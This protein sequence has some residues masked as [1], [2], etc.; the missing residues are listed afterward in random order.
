MPM[1][2]LFP[3]NCPR[4]S[5]RI[6]ALVAALAAAATS[7]QTSKPG[8]AVAFAPRPE[9]YHPGWIDL[10]K[11]GRKDVYEDPAAP[12]DAR[13]DDLLARMTV[14]EKTAQMVTL[15][16]YGRVLDD[17]LPTLRWKQ[18][19]WKDG[20]ANIDEHLNA[21][22]DGN[23]H[24]DGAKSQYALDF[25]KH[26]WAMDQVQRFFIEQTRL[27]IPADFTNEGLRG[28]PSAFS[29]NFPSE[30][31]VGHT[32]DPE[33]AGR[34]GGVMAIE[35]RAL[36]YTNIY[37]PVLDVVRDQRWGRTEESY[38]EDPFLA[39]RMGVAMVKGLQ[40]D[41]RIASTAKHFAVY[42]ANKGARE[43]DARTDPQVAPREVEDVL[44]PPFEAAIREAGLLGVMSSYNDYDGVPIT[45][46]K[47]WLTDR[48]RKE[49]GFRGYVVSDS[50]AVEFLHSKHAV[51]GDYKEAVRQA[52]DAG[53][54]VR[55][56]FTPPEVYLTPLRALVREG[57]LPMA[58]IDARVRDVLRVKFMLGLFDHPYIGD[59]KA[60]RAKVDTEE[61]RALA[62]RAARE[63]L[64]LLKNKEGALPLRKDLKT[65][66]VIGPNA[67]DAS[68]AHRQYGPTGGHAISVREGIATKLGSGVEVRY[69]KGVEI[70]G[71]NW[72]S[73]EILPE[74][75]TAEEQAGIDEAVRA[76]KGADIAVV[77]LGDGRRTVGESR[78]RTSLDLP[79][80]Q[81]ALLEAVAA[82]G[83]PVVLVL[84]NGRPM[85]V[86]WADAH[87]PAILEAWF[88]GNQG[89]TAVADALFGDDNPGGKLTVTFPKT[90]GQ[91]PFNFPTKPNAQWEGERSRVNGALYNFGHGLSY[92]T[93]AYDN[94]RVTPA[95]QRNG[96]N[97][98]VAVD[99]RNS[100]ARAGDEVVQL[101]TRDVVSS[102]TTYE[103]NLRG[104][105]RVHL[106]PGETRTIRFTLKPADLALLNRKMQRVV[107]PGMFRVMVGSASDDI[108]Q[109]GEFEIV[110]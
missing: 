79:G 98:E 20:V 52:V 10:D 68:Y 26:V 24:G 37:A 66:A 70:A 5:L 44:L 42:S 16:G 60:A 108:R 81:E 13:I 40:R 34:I 91:I 85:S 30:L 107:E 61:D 64:V 22:G 77:V 17:E 54:N 96:G 6:V 65:I 11:N 47:Y 27:G 63:S 57:K 4:S 15:Y 51:A 80:R 46:S 94:L 102:V 109:Q 82:T 45:G 55:T 19:P 59:A 56:T 7:A 41:H 92:T 95:K 32:W 69:A 87:V 90:A 35:A 73:I 67:D 106:A 43:G 89:G 48:L 99:V 29:T 39:S 36:G 104:F 62:L 110:E 28:V 25:D 8:T 103:K 2:P 38:G 12:I 100:G 93:F 83:T 101:Y 97:V 72:P 86:N 74:P 14:D 31:G 3:P 33:L 50:D 58:T 1:K 76:A 75:L 53:L 71:K 9:L 88:P 21:F 18:Q 105:E 84:I 49:F 78:S 23:E